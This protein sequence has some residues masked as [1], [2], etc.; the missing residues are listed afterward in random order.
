MVTPDELRTLLKQHRWTIAVSTS[1][2]QQVYAAKQ[3][4]GKRLVTRYI[5]TANKLNSLTEEVILE[6]LYRSE[7]RLN[8]ADTKSGADQQA[9]LERT[10]LAICSNE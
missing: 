1:G 4:R 10:P 5:G 9:N 7:A 6:K 3:R 2:R 8:P